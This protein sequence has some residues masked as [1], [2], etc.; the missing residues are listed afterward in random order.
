MPPDFLDRL[1]ADIRNFQQ[2]IGEEAKGKKTHVDAAILRPVP[3]DQKLP[4]PRGVFFRSGCKAVQRASLLR[5]AD[6]SP[7]T[8]WTAVY[9]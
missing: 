9:R 8:S 7:L 1:N 4:S 3:L 6:R 2:A 5:A